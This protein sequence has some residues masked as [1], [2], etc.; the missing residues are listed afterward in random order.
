MSGKKHKECG[1]NSTAVWRTSSTFALCTDS[2]LNFREA[3]G[4]PAGRRHMGKS[5]ELKNTGVDWSGAPLKLPVLMSRCPLAASSLH[6]PLQ[7][8]KAGVEGGK[9]G[10]GSM[11]CS[12]K[13]LAIISFEAKRACHTGYRKTSGWVLPVGKMIEGGYMDPDQWASEAK[14]ESVRVD[15]ETVEKFWDDNVCA[16]G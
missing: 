11:L 1:V 4:L 12:G 13:G 7:Q 14:T 9:K 5:Y 8:E 10:S 2:L 15:A 16:P 6:T 3:A